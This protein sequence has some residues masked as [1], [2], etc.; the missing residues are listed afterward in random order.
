MTLTK[1]SAEE[2]LEDSLKLNPGR[3]VAH[4]YNVALA[5]KKLPIVLVF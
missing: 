4:S 3:W 2:L 5:A 1:E